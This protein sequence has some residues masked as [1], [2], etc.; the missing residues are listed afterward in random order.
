MSQAFVLEFIELGRENQSLRTQLE[1]A[2]SSLEL[3]TIAANYGYNFTEQEIVTAFQQQ[4][5]LVVKEERLLTEKDLEAVAGGGDGRWSLS[6]KFKYDGGFGGEV[7]VS[8][9]F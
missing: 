8:S 7:G 5:L 3:K 6:A 2:S 1:A 9:S 4:G